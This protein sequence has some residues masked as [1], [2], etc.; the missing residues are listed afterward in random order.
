[1][2][3]YLFIRVSRQEDIET[4]WWLWSEEKEVV[5]DKGVILR[6]CN[7]LGSLAK[8]AEGRHAYILLSTA[9][10]VLKTVTLPIEKISSLD[11]V[12]PFLLEESLASDVE[13]L[14]FS[15]LNRE[16]STLRIAVADSMWL[17]QI[18]DELEQASIKVSRVLPDVLAIPLQKKE[19]LLK[20]GSEYLLRRDKWAGCVI[21]ESWRKSCHSSLSRCKSFMLSTDTSI[22]TVLSKGAIAADIIFPTGHFTLGSERGDAWSTWK[23]N[24]YALLALI[25]LLMGTVSYQTYRLDYQSQ[26]L[27][28]EIQRIFRTVFPKKKRIPTANYLKG[29]LA[30]EVNRLS[31]STQSKSLFQVFEILSSLIGENEQI[32]LLSLS[33]D[34]TRSEF[35]IEIGGTNFQV[36]EAL[37]TELSHLFLVHQGSLSKENDKVIGSLTLSRK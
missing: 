12:I 27:N 14:H 11:K 26:E 21:P 19:L 16:K 9:D 15:L 4:H 22:Y 6:S 20:L 30:S 18:L 13:E 10:V 32:E 36:C 7:G 1:M 23:K 37:R 2:H 31:V 25:I 17:T 34:E 28:H 3:E 8:V 35:K 33:Y 24:I 29:Q 5:L